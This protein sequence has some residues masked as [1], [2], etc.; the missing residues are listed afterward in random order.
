[1]AIFLHLDSSFRSIRL[2]TES[3]V[4]KASKLEVIIMT[5]KAQSQQ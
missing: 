3:Q 2:D 1:M 5:T 4:L